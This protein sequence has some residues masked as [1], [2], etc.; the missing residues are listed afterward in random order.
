MDET[1]L[2][3]ICSFSHSDLYSLNRTSSCLLLKF[4]RKN[5]LSPQTLF[6]DA[7]GHKCR[8]EKSFLMSPWFQGQVHNIVSALLCHKSRSRW[9]CWGCWSQ[10]ESSTDR[11]K[12]P[13]QCFHGPTSQTQSGV[14][15]IFC[16]TWKPSPMPK[17]YL[18]ANLRANTNI[19]KQTD[20]SRHSKDLFL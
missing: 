9:W 18:T 14:E 12:E 5:T 2:F 13:L 16:S 6:D 10:S 3:L 20:C 1:I 7:C 4:C 19:E 15:M 11:H 17:C 8:S